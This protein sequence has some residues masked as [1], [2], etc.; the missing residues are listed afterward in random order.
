LVQLREPVNKFPDFVRFVVQQLKALCPTMGKRKIAGTLVRAGM[1]LGT[2]TVGNI[3]KEEP[4]APPEVAV[5]WGWGRFVISE[6][7]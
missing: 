6:N 5:H 1:H 4:V 3:L 2:T 7:S